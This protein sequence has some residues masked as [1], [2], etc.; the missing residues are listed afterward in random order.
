MILVVRHNNIS[1]TTPYDYHNDDA[2]RDER[3]QFLQVIHNYLR[4]VPKTTTTHP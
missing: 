2:R 1:P 4:D 3:D